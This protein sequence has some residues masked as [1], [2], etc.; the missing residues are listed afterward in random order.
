MSSSLPLPPSAV[1]T[2]FETALARARMAQ[3]AQLDAIGDIRDA[4]SLR[5]TV[6]RDD[7]KPLVESEP[8]LSSFARLV[9]M[10]ED[11]PP[12]L[13]IDLVTSVTMEARSRAYRIEVDYPDGRAVAL[14]SDDRGEVRRRIVELLAHRLIERERVTAARLPR[15]DSAKPA[16]FNGV[17]LL[18]WLAGFTM[19]ALA[20]LAAGVALLK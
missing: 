14:E 17:L 13:W 10:T 19:G 15:G 8:R 7:L 1:R 12:R 16:S 4:Q 18:A 9:L 20:L 3:S 6:L 2:E 11:E 5:L